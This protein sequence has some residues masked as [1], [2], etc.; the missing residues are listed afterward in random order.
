M[1][2]ALNDKYIH[3]EEDEDVLLFNP[4]T[5]D[6][7]LINTTGNEIY[8]LCDGNNKREDIFA[9]F[10]NRHAN[11]EKDIIKKDFDDFIKKAKELELIKEIA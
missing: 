11:I 6:I 9:E 7:K 2:L 4:D 10:A 3:R 8:K 5:G 1:R